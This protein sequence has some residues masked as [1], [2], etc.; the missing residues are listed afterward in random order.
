MSQAPA[1]A[2][3]PLM[4]PD[5]VMTAFNFLRSLQV[6]D[7]E[8][9]RV[10]ERVEP[11]LRELLIDVAERIVP[12]IT[13]LPSANEGDPCTASFALEALRRVVLTTLR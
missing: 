13:A 10:T 2:P 6:G 12:P 5:S 11:R 3:L 8:M 4:T 9:A 7:T 1:T